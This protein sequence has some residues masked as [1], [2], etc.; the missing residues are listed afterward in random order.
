MPGVNDSYFYLAFDTDERGQAVRAF[1]PRQAENRPEAIEA[2]KKL[3]LAHAGAVAWRRHVEPAV[4][5]LG[6]PEVLFSSGHVGDFN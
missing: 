2:A 3:A 6:P 5:E 1:D 4:G